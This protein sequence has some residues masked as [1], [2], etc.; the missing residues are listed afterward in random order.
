MILP[1]WLTKRAELSPN[2][3]AIIEDEKEYTF[4]QLL[5]DV[6]ILSGRLSTLGLKK[7]DHVA[8]A[9]R[10]TYDSV[11]MIHAMQSLGIVMVLLNTRLTAREMA[12]QMEDSNSKFFIYDELF[13]DKAQQLE[14]ISS[15]INTLTLTEL[16]TLPSGSINLLSEFDLNDIH[17]IIYTSGT[18]GNPKG[19]M[20]TNGN[21]WWSA[22]GSVLNLGL[23]VQ[24]RWL[25]CLPLFH[26]SGLSILMRSVIYG[27]SIVL[28]EGFEPKKVNLAIEKQNVTIISVVS[29]M[30]QRMIDELGEDQYPSS[31]RCVLL[32]GGPAPKPLLEE[33]MD[34]DIPVFQTYGMTETASQI[35]T[36]APEYMLTKLGSA[37][38]P[39]FPSQLRIEKDSKEA[40]ANAI[41][42]IVV[43]GPN[44]TSGYY[45]RVDKTKEVLKDGWLYT[46]DLG[47]LDQDGFLFVV[48]RR[49][50]L[51]IS[52][53]ENIYPAEIESVLMGYPTV[54]EAGVTGISHEKWGQV[55][56]AFVVLESG[57]L[58]SE[59]E[60]K[61]FCEQHLARYKIP[62]RFYMIDELP[63]NASNKLLRRKLLELIPNAI[64]E[65]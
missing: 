60:L 64:Q 18:T 5:N 38:K 46:G 55:P 54:K 35:V 23:D 44:V 25:A 22:T 32:G 63:R 24:D 20:L 4:A 58:A 29:V 53:G 26:V 61:D 17:T 39:L 3:I 16:K 1:N 8:L 57:H 13:A 56:I 10:N 41:G 36:L 6:E 12:W 2:R 15:I 30:L 9:L 49:N 19:V 52:G 40:D 51:I 21:H 27:I 50:D 34:K 11:V 59:Q 33:C 43:K 62:Q 37:G 45:Q 28:H 47:Y 7:G 42:E 48:D 14:T 65:Q 31:L